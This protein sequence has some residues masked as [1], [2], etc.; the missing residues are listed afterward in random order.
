[1]LNNRKVKGDSETLRMRRVH[2]VKYARP[3]ACP[4]TTNF[5][6]APNRVVSCGGG[7]S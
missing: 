4:S 1:M 5:D 2:K 6:I 3:P 7:I